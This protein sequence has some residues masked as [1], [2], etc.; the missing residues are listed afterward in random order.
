M[1]KK[2]LITE[3]SR[4]L[5]EQFTVTG[6]RP[7]LKRLIKIIISS[8]KESLRKGIVRFFLKDRKVRNIFPSKRQI[9]YTFIQM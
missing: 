5:I 9:L 8:M 3:K 4:R 7:G 6:I 2:L 1:G